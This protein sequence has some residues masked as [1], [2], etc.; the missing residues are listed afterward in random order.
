MGIIKPL[1]E[2]GIGMCCNLVFAIWMVSSGQELNL[3]GKVA[4]R[5]LLAPWLLPF[6]EVKSFKEME[7]M[8]FCDCLEL[9]LNQ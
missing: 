5:A 8:L 1:G 6:T 7:A 2:K 3:F 9:L 4:V